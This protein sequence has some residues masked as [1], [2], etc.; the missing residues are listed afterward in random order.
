MFFVACDETKLNLPI[1][2]WWASAA[3]DFLEEADLESN[4]AADR[5]VASRDNANGE[6]K[7]VRDER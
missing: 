6:I 3:T 7:L 4:C 1:L 5:E 2:I